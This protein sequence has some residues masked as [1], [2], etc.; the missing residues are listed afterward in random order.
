V[1]RDNN[2]ANVIFAAVL[3]MTKFHFLTR[4]FA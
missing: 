3:D 4:A 2:N 1:A